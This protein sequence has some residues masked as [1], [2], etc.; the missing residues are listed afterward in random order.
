VLAT[1]ILATLA[2]NRHPVL[3]FRLPDATDAQQLNIGDSLQ[4]VGDF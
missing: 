1:C 3:L 2:A 4:L